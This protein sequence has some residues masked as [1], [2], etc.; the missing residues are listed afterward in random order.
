MIRA[1]RKLRAL[2]GTEWA[3]LALGA[4]RLVVV[5]A[6]LPVTGIRRLRRWTDAGDSDRSGAVEVERWCRRAVA[7]RRI[8][9]R[10]PGCRCLARSM[11]LSWWM[12]SAGVAHRLRI[13]VAGTAATLRSHSWIE[14]AGVVVDDEAE[15]VRGF[16]EI[17]EI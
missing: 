16:R 7:L 11:A 13:G 4:P 9:A 10:L 8:G 1:V 2:S 6:L 3:D 15:N 12:G 5:W 17:V 14:V